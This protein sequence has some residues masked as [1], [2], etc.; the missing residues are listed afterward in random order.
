MYTRKSRLSSFKQSRLIEHFVAGTT[1]RAAA[2]IIGVQA[3]TAITLYMRLRK[4]IAE[5]LPSYE[6]RGEVEVDERYFGGVR[7]G[8]RG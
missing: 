8:K 1:A 6:P 5:K 7:K 2:Q 3:N 4:L